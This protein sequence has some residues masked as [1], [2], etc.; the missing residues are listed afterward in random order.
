MESSSSYDALLDLIVREHIY[1]TAD[2]SLSI[3]LRE[4]NPDS[5]KDLILLAEQYRNAHGSVVSDF[6]RR[7]RR[8]EKTRKDKGAFGKDRRDKSPLSPREPKTCYTCGKVGHFSTKCPDGMGGRSKKGG[9]WSQE[10]RKQ[11]VNACVVGVCPPE[12][13]P[14]MLSSVPEVQSPYSASVKLMCGHEIPLLYASCAVGTE[15]YLCDAVVN[16]KQIQAMRDSGC[17]SVIVRTG[18]VQASQFTGEKRVCLLIDRTVRIMPIATL[19]VS[20]PY[21]DGTVTALCV[22]NPIYDLVIGNIPGVRKPGDENPDWKNPLTRDGE[23][24]VREEDAPSQDCSLDDS[25]VVTSDGEQHTPSTSTAMQPD[26]SLEIPR[27]FDQVSETD[28]S[29]RSSQDDD[30]SQDLPS[31]STDEPP[32]LGDVEQGAGVETRGIKR[33]KNRPLVRLGSS[34]QPESTATREDVI[35]TQ[36]ADGTLKKLAEIA[37]KG[38]PKLVGKNCEVRFYFKNDLL[39]REYRSPTISQGKTFNQLVVPKPFR[40]QVLRLAHDSALSGHLKTRKTTDRILTQFYW[41]GLQSD[42]KRYCAS[43]D[44]C[45]RTMPKGRIGKVPLVIPPLIDT[46]FKR[47]AVD[48][49]GP[50][51][52]LPIV[53]TGIS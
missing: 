38:E 6:G 43:C 3:F 42:V 41:P 39:F 35:A 29:Q 16:G 5:V 23:T 40:S 53:G 48:L 2:R 20:T 22:D 19:Y 49:I 9:K 14:D 1:E 7:A 37:R 45:Q 32:I 10:S 8:D 44:A 15:M 21:Y 33:R 17:T 50:I 46:C 26:V 31:K 12:T 51:D 13:S 47:I 28:V 25:G 24:L 11:S 4:R 34:E 36:Q 30:V 27:G 18:L 52:L